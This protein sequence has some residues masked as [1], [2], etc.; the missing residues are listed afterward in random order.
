MSLTLYMAVS[1]MGGCPNWE[2]SCHEERSVVAENRVVLVLN[3]AGEANKS[4]VIV[5][6]I[7]SYLDLV[8]KTVRQPL[9]TSTCSG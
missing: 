6:Q 7:V 3:G 9:R 1:D 2:M 8:L 4:G 5:L